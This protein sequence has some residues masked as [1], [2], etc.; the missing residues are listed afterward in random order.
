MK[1]ETATKLKEYID[2]KRIEFSDVEE[3]FSID[4]DLEDSEI[5]ELVELEY[6]KTTQDVM[7]LFQCVLKNAIKLAITATKDETKV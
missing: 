2:N 3:G 6:G 1:Q 4:F 5:L 7:A